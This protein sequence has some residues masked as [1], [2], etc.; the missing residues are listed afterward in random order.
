MSQERCRH[1]CMDPAKLMSVLIGWGVQ[2]DRIDGKTQ[3][4]V[5]PAQA[6]SV[7]THRHEGLH[8]P[9]CIHVTLLVIPGSIFHRG[10]DMN[11][12]TVI[13]IT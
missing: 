5:A 8:T 3:S 4:R 1:L 6:Q 13:L 12:G 2:K 10:G 9:A 11:E 7:K